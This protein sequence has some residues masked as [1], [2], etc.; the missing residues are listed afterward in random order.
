MVP[1]LHPLCFL[2]AAADAKAK[3]EAAISRL[4]AEEP[5]GMIEHND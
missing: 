3:A 1:P 2:K 4:Q 5:H